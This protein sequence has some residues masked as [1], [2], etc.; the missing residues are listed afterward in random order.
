[1]HSSYAL[2]SSDFAVERGGKSEPL[3][4]LW[5]GGYQ[6]DDRL[7]VLLANPMDAVGCSNLIC[8]TITLFYDN[9]RATYGTGNFFRYSDAFLFGVGCEP[10]DFNQLDVW[11]LHKFVTVLQP[12]TEAV[13]EAI[14][15]RR[16]TLL[17]VPETGA[18]CRGEVVLSTWNTFVHQVRAVVTYSARTGMARDADVS[19]VGNKVVESYVEQAIFSTPGLSAGEQARLRRLRRTID[20]EEKQS[21]EGYRT[22]AGPAAARALLG[23][24]QVL[25]PGHQEL[26]RRA[27]P[28]T[29]LPVEMPVPQLDTGSA[30]FDTAAAAA[31]QIERS[32]PAGVYPEGL[33]RTAF[34]AVQRRMGGSFAEWEG[35]DWISDFGD[36]VSEHHTVREAVGVWDESPLQKWLFR[37]ADAL[38]AADYCFTAD[39]AALEVGQARYGPFVDDHGRMLGDGVVYNTGDTKA[40]MLVVTAL[41]TD[42]AH[43][44]RILKGRFKTTIDV[45]TDRMP[46]LQVQGPRSR[47]LL[48]SLTDADVEGLRYFRFLP[49]PVTVGGVEGC[50]ISRTGYS[51]E[52]GYEVFCPPEGAE[53]L[54][55]TL[56]DQGAALGIRP[57]G[58]AAVESL[59]IEAGLIFLGYD[60]FQGVT[61]PFHVNLD[62]M[63]KLDGADFH[64]R[65]ALIAERDAGIT[66]RMVTL[67]VAGEE[68]PDY[69]APVYS[70]GRGVGRLTSPS[71]GR[72][73]TVDKVIGMA[74]IETELT[75]LGT[76]VEVAMPDG[77]LVPAVVDTYPIYDPQKTRPRG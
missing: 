35:W 25:P 3:A 9:L 52:L 63:I 8:A 53:R 29:I 24:T 73:P 42:A 32:A 62:R 17:A 2:A 65:D 15:D 71:A 11:P 55:Q 28:T 22:L 40:G 12:T 47:E 74:S 30:P 13:L 58:L 27:T 66:H 41:D 43:F 23:V 19:L 18:R 76:Q 38:E 48:Q 68:P 60:Y 69:G 44:R 51:G 33:R 39:M 77:R 36:P 31:L 70:N 45:A 37:G 26:T 72:S 50:M 7:G 6:P 34:D 14:N 10:G 61:S 67:V 54:W 4:N 56:L 75:E 5:P 49:A 46:H 1:M 21:V 16:V 59:R 20:R 64:G 57:Y